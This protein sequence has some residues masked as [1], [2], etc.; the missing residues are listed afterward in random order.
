MT[1]LQKDH[2]FIVLLFYNSD[3]FIWIIQVQSSYNTSC[4][5]L[6]VFK[7]AKV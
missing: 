7:L 6:C 1:P 2:I 5:E 3:W 4:I